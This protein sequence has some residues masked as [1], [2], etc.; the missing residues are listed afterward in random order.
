MHYDRKKRLRE[1][2]V[3]A[4]QAAR[5]LIGEYAVGENLVRHPLDAIQ[6]AP[7]A[8][9]SADVATAFLC[10]RPPCAPATAIPTNAARKRPV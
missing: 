8:S 1:I 9:R 2:I 5:R 6:I 3:A 4:V 7:N 10:P